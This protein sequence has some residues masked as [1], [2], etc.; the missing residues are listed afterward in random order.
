MIE[1][2][3]WLCDR[4]MM[5]ENIGILYELLSLSLFSW[6]TEKSVT[7]AGMLSF[8][9]KIIVGLISNSPLL[10]AN[11]MLPLSSLVAPLSMNVWMGRVLEY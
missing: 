7:F 9:L 1:N 11:N 2:V 3:F 5:S 6:N 8:L 10:D 4:L